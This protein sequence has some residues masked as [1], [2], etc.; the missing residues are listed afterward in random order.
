MPKK[1]IFVS[2]V[3]AILL[4][5]SSFALSVQNNK[6]EISTE[7]IQ[8]Y[9]KISNSD[10]V[11]L[12]YPL[13]SVPI[14]VKQ[15]GNFTIQFQTEEFNDLF[16]YISTA[17]E[18]VIDEFSLI[19]NNIFFNNTIW[20]VQVDLPPSVP[21]ELYNLTIVINLNNQIFKDIQP[22]AVSVVTEFKDDFSFIHITD[23]HVGDPRGLIE[24]VRK[25]IGLK[26]LKKCIEE[27]NLLHPDF[28][29]ISGDLV[30]G[31]L[32]PFEYSKEYKRCYDLLQMF[33]VPTYLCPGNHDGYRK[34]TEDGF[35]FWDKYF[36]P[37]YYSFDYGDN[38]FIACNSYDMPNIFRLTI[39]FLPLTWGGNI[40]DQQ[41]NWIKD[42]LEST[43]SKNTFIFIHHNPLW[44]TIR[45]SFIRKKYQNREEL[46]SLI[47]QYNVKMVLAGHVHYD[48]VT[49]FNDTI[50]L[51]TTTPESSTPTKDGYWGYRMITIKDNEIV[52]YNYKEPKYSIPT[53]HLSTKKREGL[54]FASE[55]IT[56][57]LE[58][59]IQA[60]VKF[61]MPKR[62]YTV[63]NGIILQ[64][65][66]G[67]DISEVYVSVNASKQ[68]ITKVSLKPK[69]LSQD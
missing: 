11:R 60:L 37:Q 34:I 6:I 12:L 7:K 36:G 69:T 20:Y 44:G 32:Y 2:I 56:N 68:S 29:I 21:E 17:Y 25:T 46:I 43:D 33:D 61:V 18:P 51:T 66:D 38:H 1:I 15:N 19:I 67:A 47:D 59:D 9:D 5:S 52:S 54:L 45:E 62:N 40:G 58:M 16:I 28:V 65:R 26:S 41:F 48:N 10:N 30:F 39:S 14:I 53:Y 50:Y 49:I 24:S 22:R 3:L 35:E 13:S 4:L 64:K 23:F 42:N 8:Y 63:D 31:Q 27:I 57:D 55:T